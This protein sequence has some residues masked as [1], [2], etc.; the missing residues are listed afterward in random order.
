MGLEN[1]MG[2]QQAEML[3]KTK[4]IRRRT[5]FVTKST[6]AGVDK[7]SSVVC[8]SVWQSIHGIKL[9]TLPFLGT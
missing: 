3:G 9:A 8:M 6:E 1:E 2:F 5:N 4:C 7:P